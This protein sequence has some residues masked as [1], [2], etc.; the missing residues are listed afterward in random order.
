MRPVR[1]SACVLGL[2]LVVGLLSAC[3]GSSSRHDEKPGPPD[4]QLVAS[5][6][7]FRYDEGTPNV[8]TGI[9]NNS[10]KPI[11]VTTATISWS[12]F[13]WPTVKL[14]DSPVPPSQTAAFISRFG[15]PNCT[16]HP[17]D[18]KLLAVVNGVRRSLPLHV[19]EPG[20]LERL[21]A[22]ACAQ[23]RLADAASVVLSIGTSVVHSQGVPAF[24]GTVT[25][26]RPHTPGAAV[27]V[28]DLGGSVLF[29]VLP[30]QG[31]RLRPF[32]LAPDVRTATIPIRVGPTQ[33][34]DAHTRGN[35]SQTFLFSV[36][37]RTG[38]DPVHRTVSI[39]GKGIQQRLLGLLDRYCAHHKTN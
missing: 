33:R 15:R 18:P 27:T 28:E 38:D 32:R 12:G 23:Q 5:A 26:T 31:R 25:L 9:T 11:T 35:S 20:L 39:P 22:S 4:S 17:S 19:D 8:E 30:R 3:G 16:T 2:A 1:R 13:A 34:C 36:Y 14:P 7:Q 21:R 24:A 6:G 10:S 29:D 37:S